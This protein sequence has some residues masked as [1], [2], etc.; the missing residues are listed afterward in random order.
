L[1]AAVARV[2]LRKLA[3]PAVRLNV[4]HQAND[5]RAGLALI[6]HAHGLFAEVRG[7]GLMIGAVLADAWKGKAAAILDHAA[8]HGLLLLQAGPDVLRFLP[9]L[10]IDDDELADGLARL[11]A[12]LRDFVAG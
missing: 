8:G 11:G 3:S 10:T 4:E 5:L 6:N 12:A 1:A 7:R 9:P 2:A